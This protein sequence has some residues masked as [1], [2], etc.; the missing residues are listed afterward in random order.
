[1]L[2]CYDWITKVHIEEIITIKNMKH[3]DEKL[4][5]YLLKKG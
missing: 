5:N 4:T 2:N 3:Y 1:L